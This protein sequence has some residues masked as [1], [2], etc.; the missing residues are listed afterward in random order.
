M[1]EDRYDI[2]NLQF[3]LAEEQELETSI[4]R[5]KGQ[6]TGLQIEIDQ[7]IKL[8]YHCQ[9]AIVDRLDERQKRLESKDGQM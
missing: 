9:I 5:K 1:K 8:L 6:L 7:K 4:N 3:L 2:E